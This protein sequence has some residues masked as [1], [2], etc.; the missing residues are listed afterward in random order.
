MAQRLPPAA[1]CYFAALSSAEVRA[2]IEALEW[3]HTLELAPGVT[4]PGWFD[5]RSIASDLPLPASL[6]G[7]RCLDVGTFDG[8][9]AFEMERRGA[10]EVVAID[11]LDPRGWDWPAGSR[12]E[13]VEEIGKRKRRGEGFEFARECLESSV[14][15]LELSVYDL[16]SAVAGVFDFVYLGSLLLHLRDPV[17]AL[18]RIRAVCDGQLL[19]VDAVDPLLSLIFRKRPVAALDARGRPWWWYANPAGIERMLEA[20]G[21]SVQ[22]DRRII[23][24]PAGRGQPVGPVTPRT[25]LRRGGWRNGLNAKRGDPHVVIEA[26][27]M[28]G[29]QPLR[30]EETSA[31]PGSGPK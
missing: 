15:R 22:A 7:K 19:V 6:A 12:E 18:S 4:T 1:H 23:Y 30:A 10:E 29:V 16:D 20:A 5:T 24:M 8:F 28:A 11:V 25:L 9:W 14:R 21:F 31:G 2:R 17:L 26:T 13:T 3:Y 27:P